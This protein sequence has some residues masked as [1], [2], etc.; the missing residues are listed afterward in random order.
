MEN[1]PGGFPSVAKW[2]GACCCEGQFLL[3]LFVT[4]S[5]YALSLCSGE[6]THIGLVFRVTWTQR[7]PLFLAEFC[8]KLMHPAMQK[9]K[10]FQNRPDQ[11]SGDNS[12]WDNSP[13][14]L[15]GQYSTMSYW[16][17]C[18]LIPHLFKYIFKNAQRVIFK[19]VDPMKKSWEERDREAKTQGCSQ[20]SSV[21][22]TWIQTLFQ[23]ISGS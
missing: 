7:Q 16:A 13:E 1:H 23:S 12:S 18:P 14:A 9:A 19:I 22:T 10:Q 17:V 2:G 3:C 11:L 15:A 8:F 20:P 21:L 6:V 4:A 5:A